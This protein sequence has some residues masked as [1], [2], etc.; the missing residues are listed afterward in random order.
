MLPFEDV[1]R[2]P[3]VLYHSCMIP[4]MFVQETWRG[5]ENNRNKS[6][7]IVVKTQIDWHNNTA[8]R[9]TWR[10]G[11]DFSCTRGG[12][13]T[14]WWEPQIRLRAAWAVS[15]EGWVAWDVRE[16]N[17]FNHYRI[18]VTWMI[19]RMKRR[20]VEWGESG[21]AAGW[22]WENRWNMDCETCDNES[23]SRAMLQGVVRVRL[24]SGGELEVGNWNER[25]YKVRDCAHDGEYTVDLSDP[26]SCHRGHWAK[27][28]C[29]Y[30]ILHLDYLKQWWKV[31]EYVG[32][33][34][35]KPSV[36]FWLRR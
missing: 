21:G 26:C 7:R 5:E 33:D 11:G 25:V 9:R 18:L 23:T 4:L 2:S 31:W 19:L 6:L 30:V 34:K 12:T 29:V 22:G 1:S 10:R 13:T 3:W 17:L 28:P 15:A 24:V 8:K 16:A 32:D 14:W 20:E 35:P 27:T 36:Q